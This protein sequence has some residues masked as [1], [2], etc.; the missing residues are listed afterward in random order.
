MTICKEIFYYNTLPVVFNGFIDQPDCSDGVISLICR[1]KH[2]ANPEKNR[3][4]A[5]S[6][7]ICK[8]GEKIGGISLRVGYTEGLYYGGNIGYGVDKAQRGNG[9][10]ARACKLLATIAQ[11]HSI[12]KLLITNE[13]S[14]TASMRVCEKLGAH[15][16]RTVP[17][18]KWHDLYQKGQRFVN[19]YEWSIN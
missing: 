6:F 4:P 2:P 19:I 15:L 12:T 10:A 14:N 1:E 11:A 3:V 9:Y 7:D 18:P 8:N 5:Y 16:L 13:H 17:L